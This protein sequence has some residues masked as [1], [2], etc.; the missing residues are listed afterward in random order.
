MD[1]NVTQ[2][3]EAEFDL[4]SV[5]FP[6]AALYF[7]IA[8]AMVFL[9]RILGPHSIR[10]YR[11]ES[12]YDDST[13]AVNVIY[14][15]VAP[16]A[17]CYFLLCVFAIVF[18]IARIDFAFPIRWLP[19]ALYWVQMLFLKISSRLFNVP[20]WA[21]ALEALFSIAIAIYFDWAVVC[22]L[23]ENGLLAVDQ[24]NI[25]FQVVAAVFFAV[26]EIVMSAAIRKRYKD[27]FVIPYRSS[28]RTWSYYRSLLPTEKTLYEYRRKYG[29]Q[30]PSR[31]SEDIL[32]RSIFYAVMFIE[33]SNRP[34]SARILEN[35][36]AK[37]KLAKTTGIMQQ[38]A[39]RVLTDEESVELAIPYIEDMWNKFLRNFA[40]SINSSNLE[41]LIT[42]A[43]TG[44]YYNYA[45]VR[46][47]ISANFS[48]L[49]GDY[50]GTRTLNANSIFEAVR[51]FEERENYCLVP[52]K[53]LASGAVFSEIDK[54]IPDNIFYWANDH[55]VRVAEMYEPSIQITSQVHK[56]QD[57]ILALLKSLRMQGYKIVS[58]SFGP[59]I[60]QK[61]QIKGE[62]NSVL[63]VVE[64][65]WIINQLES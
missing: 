24:S 45:S 8:I 25:G 4:F 38:K 34:R 32:L 58:V 60:Y 35:F 15:I 22:Q 27:D 56:T 29:K 40:Q 5:D 55:E 62:K 57:D 50:C 18:A 23:P 26:V 12:D 44:Y 51:Q 43:R 7:F 6:C 46:D 3:F 52:E 41:P 17:W 20:P 1:N 16:V 39:S 36:L 42:F 54:Y 31:F 19:V 47:A 13:G 2:Y 64:T 65:G 59:A 48:L 14:R 53:V 21:F 61:V 10:G 9:V 33:D 49:Y 28:Y 11:L 30:L 63:P 37:L